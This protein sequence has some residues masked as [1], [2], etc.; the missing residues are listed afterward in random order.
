LRRHN[1]LRVVLVPALVLAAAGGAL[2]WWRWTQSQPRTSEREP[3]N[4]L[5]TATRIALDHPVRGQIGRRL[6][7]A[8]GDKDFYRVQVG[9]RPGAPVKLEAELTAIRNIDLDL[10]VMDRTGRRLLELDANGQGGGE[11]LDNLGITDDE[12]YLAVLES[13]DDGGAPAV[14]TENVTDSYQLTVH[15]GAF[16]AD[17]EREPNEADSDATPIAAGKP[18]RGRL[19]RWRDLDKFRF[20]GAPGKYEVTLG[21]DGLPPAKLRAGGDEAPPGKPIT[22][23]L[24]KGDV[25]AVER[26][27]P[28]APIGQRKPQLGVDAVYTVTI[29][30]P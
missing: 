4:D 6:S 10:V 8:E 26:V 7:D 11:K 17:E 9:G 20:D 16:A 30:A 21:G 13:S 2:V 12:V 3:N 1:L 14:P 18:M 22:V 15:A 27:D 19:A 29:A 5:D 25:I 24:Q 28:D 23:D